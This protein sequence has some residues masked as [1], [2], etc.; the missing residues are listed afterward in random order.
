VQEYSSD[1]LWLPDGTFAV[2][3]GMDTGTT[4][5]L[6]AVAANS[7]PRPLPPLSLTRG[8]RRLAFLPGGDTFLVLRGEIQHKDL[9]LVDLKTGAERQLSH[10]DSDFEITDFDLSPDGREVVLER[11]QDR[12]DI[13]LLDLSGR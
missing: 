9:W 8:A 2:F 11:V 1:P 13:V 4:F 6:K 12:S 5:S 7:A 10:F 3:S